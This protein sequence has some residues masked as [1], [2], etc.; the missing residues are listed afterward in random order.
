MR[1]SDRAIE[2]TAVISKTTP[3]PISTVVEITKFDTACR[4]GVALRL[5]ILIALYIE[6]SHT[7]CCDSC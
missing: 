6:V 2:S 3:T 5:F 7:D 1:H 4:V